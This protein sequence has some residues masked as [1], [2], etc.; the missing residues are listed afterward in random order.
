M[1]FGKLKTGDK[2]LKFRRQR[3]LKLRFRRQMRI[4]K[5]QVEE[6]GAQAEQKL[7]NDFF[8]RLE[9]LAAVRRFVL[10][11]LLLVVL[12][13]GVV[14]SQIRGLSSYYQ[15]LS[16][17]P[18]GTYTEGVLGS[19]TNAN[20]VY[21]TSLVDSSVAELV[22]A[23][24]LAYDID[25]RLIGDLAESWKAD[26]AGTVYTLRL[27]PGLR[28]HD[29]EKLT[30]DDVVFTYNAIQNPDARSPLFESWRDIQV[31][32]TDDLTVIF[33]LPN[34]LV[35][36]PHS[37]TTG[38]IPR[39]ILGDVPM[40]SMRSVSFNS[41]R[42]VGAGP[43]KWQALELSG[44]SADKRQEKV[45]LK[46]F[47]NYSRG[48]PKLN[49][50]VIQTFRDPDQMVK[51]FQN[52]EISAIA[53]L[54]QV[55]DALKGDG[56]VR[57]YNLPLTASVMTFFRTQG[58]LLA[59]AAIRKA[60][61]AGTDTNSIIGSLQY[62]TRSVRQALLKGQ[63]GY[64]PGYNQPGYDPAAAVK[65]LRGDGWTS[66]KNGVRLKGD[67]ALSFSL[68]FLNTREYASVAKQLA[69]QWKLLG[70]DAQLVPQS[71]ED[72]RGTLS[73]GAPYDALLYGVSI[74]ADPDVYAY[75][76]SSQADPLSP[77]QLNF[78]QYRSGTAD[79]GLEAGRTRL[80]PRLRA[81]KYQPFL[82]AWQAD[83]PALGLYQP[84]FLYITHGVVHGLPE[85]P[86]NS[87][88]GRLLNV[89]NWMIRQELVT[90]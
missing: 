30:A 28:W 6:F 77:I 10:T 59:S 5:I 7:E 33:K 4:Q 41:T 67:R 65:L 45:A 53:G 62:P 76:H 29:G 78:S 43:F 79:A 37:L 48:K 68:Y 36:F 90:P 40:S 61:V 44:G 70:V 81:I 47:D 64:D 15:V 16:P 42:P 84:R 52:R 56:D 14:A 13:T 88:I 24:L 86:V 85:N 55:P 2:K 35:S 72:F 87:D 46:A 31:S 38:I 19:F 20:P 3:A 58:G 12:L 34:P 27:K 54:N 1:A 23:G 73:G 25:N 49:G 21:A 75:W 51:S 71:E 32:S 83:A 26:A 17:A 80:D 66:S 50:F 63:T 11:W 9:R 8:K 57:V 82:K 74:G 60:L 22:F 39:H 89:S 69:E 18:G